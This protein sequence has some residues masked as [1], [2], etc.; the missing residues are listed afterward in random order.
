M[1]SLQKL[2]DRLA[3]EPTTRLRKREAYCQLHYY[4]G[5]VTVVLDDRTKYVHCTARLNYVTRLCCSGEKAGYD[6]YFVGMGDALLG[7]HLFKN[8]PDYSE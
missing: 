2:I 6:S 3:A 5:C 8:A 7:Y 1:T 4:I